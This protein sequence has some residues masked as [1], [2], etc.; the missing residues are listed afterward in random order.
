MIRSSQ[1]G[2]PLDKSATH[3]TT[4]NRR[5]HDSKLFIHLL[6]IIVKIK[7]LRSL[8]T[9]CYSVLRT[10][11][12]AC[13]IITG[14]RG[15][16]KTKESFSPFLHFFPKFFIFPS[17][18]PTPPSCV[19]YTCMEGSGAETNITICTKISNDC[20]VS[21]KFYLP[22][23]YLEMLMVSYSHSSCRYE[24]HRSE[25]YTTI[26]IRLWPCPVSVGHTEEAL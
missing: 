20:S 12:R 13:T 4:V 1:W 18:F 26:L 16:G 17:F 11:A 22:S 3:F 23:V 21:W 6:M 19:Y 25:M 10:E 8:H 5:E 24:V 9:C 7:W 14:N 2:V 15:W